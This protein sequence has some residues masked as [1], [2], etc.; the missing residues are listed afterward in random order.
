MS[1]ERFTTSREVYHRIRWDPRLDAREFVIGYDTHGETLEEM[2]FEAFVPDGEIPWHRVWYFKRGRQKVWDRKER[3]DLLSQPRPT[4]TEPSPPVSTPARPGPLPAGFSALPAHR[5]DAGLGEWVGTPATASV[6][7]APSALTVATF[8]V[9]FDLYDAELLATERRTPAALALLA[10]QDADVIALQEV[11]PPFLRALLAEPWVRERYHVSEGPSADTVTPYG[12]V[13]LSKWPFAALSQRVFSRDKRLIAGQL[14]FEGGPLWVATP[15]L[16]SNRDPSGSAAR[17]AQVQA[18][19][20]WAQAVGTHQEQGAPDLVLAG[21]FNLSDGE[22]EADR[23]VQAG[24]VDAW[25]EL[26]P[27]ETGET[28]N[29]RLNDLAALTTTS[30]RLQRLD[31]VLVASGSGRLA[32]DTIALFAEAPL[33]GAPAPDGGP[34]FA[35]DHYGLS[36]VLRRGPAATTGATGAGTTRRVHHT[37]VVLIPPESSWGPIQALRKKHDAKFER[38]M[39]HVTLL[40]PFLPEEDLDAAEAVLVDAL[41]QVEP[42]EVTLAGFHHFE[43]RVNATAWLKPEDQPQGALAALHARLEQALPEC[44]TPAGHGF[45]P[46]LSVGQLPLSRD[47]QLE[48]TL[49]QWERTWRPVTF[50]AREV[51][52]IRRVGDTPFEVVRR[53]PLGR[54]KVLDAHQEDV[55]LYAAVAQVQTAPSRVPRPREEVIERLRGLCEQSGATLHLYG[56]SLLGTAGVDGDVDAVALG[57]SDLSRQDFARALTDLVAARRASPLDSARFVADAAIP[58]VK[59]SLGGLGID[60]TYASR[61]EGMDADAPPELLARQEEGLDVAGQRALLGLLDSQE[62]LAHVSREEGELEHFRALLRLVKTWAKARGLY[63][64]ALG[65]LGGLSWAVM[66]A[67]ART[68]APGAA[69]TSDAARLA[70]FFQTFA[71]WPWPQPVGLTPEAT[72]YHPDGKRDLFPV[73]APAMPARNTARNV[74]RSTVRVLR[75]ELTRALELIT[76][77]R[78]DASPAAWSALFE[79]VEPPRI[80]STRLRVS[81][82]APRS[83]LVVEQGWV[84]GHITELVYRLEGDRRLAVRP[85]FDTPAQGAIVL[86]LSIRD[87]RDAE[88][89]RWVPDSPLFRAV[90]SFKASFQAW[91]ARPPDAGLQIELLRGET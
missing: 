2:P 45:T 63:S 48:R 5:F 81:V 9:L 38:W 4:E 80:A 15:H 6:T 24:F 83:D 54:P 64:H 19:I 59:L 76:Q 90:E 68:R 70:H 87:T 17:T 8:N 88:A 85:M 49:S 14:A 65:Y 82:S 75:E 53:I 58:L 69:S 25:P 66:V 42:F 44:A 55:L 52:I 3:L 47:G 1:Q 36:C 12:Q 74:S 29:P 32:P 67:W 43:H 62:L 56:S 23:F 72:R 18:I 84:L 57:P 46:H 37:A 39:P 10:E 21:D 22:P 60:L 26:R 86:G 41:R 50:E 78:Q 20:E 31:R 40:Y 33:E 7:A 35:S 71:A 73:I 51:C 30:G 34:L 91:P 79:P 13:L 11:T 28:Y 27:S 89:L 61:P 77:A 16:T